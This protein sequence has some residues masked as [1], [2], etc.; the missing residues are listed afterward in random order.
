MASWGMTNLIMMEF[1]EWVGAAD[2]TRTGDPLWSVQAYRLGLYAIACHSFD[3][4]TNPRVAKAATLDQIT[5][6]VGSIAANIAEGYSRSSLADRNR[7]YGYALGSTREAITWYDALRI[8]LGEVTDARQ[9]TL[10]QI[11]RLLLTTLRKNR[12]AGTSAIFAD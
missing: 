8:E 11:R 3:R 7:F 2:A 1:V 6:A 10:I 5:R 4:R 12:P 9:G